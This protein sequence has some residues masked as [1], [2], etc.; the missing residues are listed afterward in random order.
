MEQSVFYGIG[1]LANGAP[2]YPMKP[3]GSN[4]I[5]PAFTSLAGVPPGTLPWATGDAFNNPSWNTAA[6]L[7]TGTFLPGVSP[8]FFAAGDDVSRGNVFTSLGTSTNYGAIT[9]PS[10][11]ASTI[12]RTNFVVSTAD[13]NHNGTVDAA[14]YVVWRDTFGSTT[15]LDA[16]GNNNGMIDQG[17]HDVWKAQFGSMPGGGAAGAD[18]NHNG[19]VDAADYVVWRDTFGSTTLLDADG[20][21]NGMIDQGDHDV[22]KAQFGTTP[23]AGTAHATTTVPEPATAVLLTVAAALMLHRRR[24]GPAKTRARRDRSTE[25]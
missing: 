12:V 24:Y 13:Y 15:L 21:N 17:D 16:D 19:T 9:T 2:E 4:S 7:V 3:V 11:I 22:W 8:G 14:D 18:Y 20:N 10:I 1:T 5:G 25:D 6:R 23:A